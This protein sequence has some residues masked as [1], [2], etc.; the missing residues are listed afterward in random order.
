[1]KVE[2]GRGIAQAVAY[3]L[4]EGNPV[5]IH[6]ATLLY[7]ISWPLSA[8]CS[9]LTVIKMVTKTVITVGRTLSRVLV[10]GSGGMVIGSLPITL[11]RASTNDS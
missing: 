7:P 2:I 3:F 1:L 8:T 10:P 11:D 6:V 5:G 4:F 9:M